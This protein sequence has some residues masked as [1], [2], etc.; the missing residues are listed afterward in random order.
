VEPLRCSDN[1]KGDAIPDVQTPQSTIND[2]FHDMKL[3]SSLYIPCED[4]DVDRNPEN[5]NQMDG[6]IPKL[7]P[8]CD[9]ENSFSSS[10]TN[11][12]NVILRQNDGVESASFCDHLYKRIV[13]TSGLSS[14]FNA[15][16]ENENSINSR[17]G[18]RTRT[19]QNQDHSNEFSDVKT[20]KSLNLFVDEYPKTSFFSLLDSLQSNSAIERIVIFRK[21]TTNKE[22]R[23]RT[24]DDMD[25][26]FHVIRNLSTSLVELVLCNFHPKDLSSFCIGIGGHPSIGYLQLHMEH[27]TLDQQSMQ[28]IA[29]MPSLVSLELE[30]N[31]S[32]PV[33]SLLESD[34][35]VLLGVLSTRF[36]FTPNDVICLAGRIRTNSVLKVL[37]LEPRIPSWC[38]GAVMASLRFSHTSRLE[39]FRFSCRNDNSEEQGDACMAEIL[40]TIEYE[41]PLRVLWNHS[42]ECFS[43]SAETRRKTL[44]A[45]SRSPS[46]E[47]FCLFAENEE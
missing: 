7:E 4:F 27:G 39:I 6:G 47:Q 46:L 40:K 2:N 41:T 35:L 37:D 43:V 8:I 18:L 29:S 42:R 33:W 13:D 19:S 31:E 11:N 5:E 10:S 1:D 26:L 30:V 28:I 38:I 44:S 12:S 36:D 22:I 32:F 16:N 3:L 24:L 34:S 20:A 14:S 15:Q 45:L 23:T 25:D 9:K 21:G 17:G